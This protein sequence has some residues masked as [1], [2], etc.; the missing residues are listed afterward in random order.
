MHTFALEGWS[1]L[2]IT[3]E[4]WP[5]GRE[6]GKKELGSGHII[7]IGGSNTKGNYKIELKDKGGRF[8]KKGEIKDFPRKRKTAWELL[9]LG[10]KDIYDK[11]D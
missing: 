7:N 5:Y 11:E 2:K 4:L 10:L 3:V 6:Y 9:Y 8:Y 1:M